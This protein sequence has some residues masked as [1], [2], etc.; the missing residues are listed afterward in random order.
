MTTTC[1]A[2]IGMPSE[3]TSIQQLNSILERPAAGAV[4]P[5]V[6][7][8]EAE[9]EVEGQRRAIA[10]QRRVTRVAQPFGDEEDVVR[11]AGP[12]RAGSV[13]TC[14]LRI[15][16][17]AIQGAVKGA[18]VKL[19]RPHWVEW[20]RPGSEALVQCQLISPTP[21]PGQGPVA[22]FTELSCS[23]HPARR[24]PVRWERQS[25]PGPPGSSRSNAAAWTPTCDLRD[26]PYCDPPSGS[27]LPDSCVV[28][29]PLTARLLVRFSV[30]LALEVVD[31]TATP[32]PPE[33]R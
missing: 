24:T 22:T 3:S 11:P 31:C 2:I 25:H 6:R 27:A 16:V 32:R 1:P 30:P 4:W 9:L 17:T 26:H 10:V 15:G 14:D 7:Q 13:I 20:L 8:G 12:A 21:L 29:V 23:F 5:G 18:P 33:C 19:E 28:R